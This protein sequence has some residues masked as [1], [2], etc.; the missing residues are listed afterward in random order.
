MQAGICRSCALVPM[1][2]MDRPMRVNKEVGFI[3]VE[4]WKW[5]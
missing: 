2:D 4:I 3:F 1:M 5:I